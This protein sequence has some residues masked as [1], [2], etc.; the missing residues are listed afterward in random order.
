MIV[1][2]GFA[3]CRDGSILK[4]NNGNIDYF[5]KKIIEICKSN[6][7][8]VGC[9][10]K[11]TPK[12]LQSGFATMEQAFDIVNKIQNNDSDY[13]YC[14]TLGH[15]LGDIETKK[16][17]GKWLDVMSRCPVV[18][19]NSGCAHGVVM[20]RFKGSEVLSESQMQIFVPDIKNACERR[21]GFNPS[22]LD[23]SFCYHSLGHLLMYLTAADID[24]SIAICKEVAV[25]PDGRNYYQTCIQGV[26]MIIFRPVDTDDQSLVERITPTKDMVLKFCSR[27]D[28][29]V[30]TACR[31]E[32][33]Q[34][35]TDWD[36]K[37]PKGLA[38]FCSFAKTKDDRIWCFDGAGMH[39]GLPMEILQ[40][41]GVASVAKYCMEFPS[42]LIT[43]C[44][45]TVATSW[46]VDGP[47]YIQDSVDLC[48]ESAVYGYSES[49]FSGLLYFSKWQYNEGSAEWLF[50]CNSLPQNYKK[51]CLT[52]NVP[53]SF[54]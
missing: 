28:G 51:I 43:R 46:I 24:K 11:F 8:K 40:S 20:R 45:Q 10:D 5:A 32:S 53:G 29:L 33:W 16:D 18:S 12:I 30:Y 15:K 26:F 35:S 13:F 6:S 39:G 49:C 25:K 14:H 42:D 47:S 50:Y 41:K 2:T 19:C 4:F 38:G 52:G 21:P 48:R 37:S 23:I 34:F 22:D 9:Y 54:R 7:Y 3:F 17:P 31:I 36:L 27:F 44:F 1:T